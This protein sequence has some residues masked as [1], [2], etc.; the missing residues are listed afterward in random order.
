MK[1]EK[2]RKKTL[3]LSIFFSSF[4]PIVTLIAF[5]MNTSTTQLADFFRRTAEL[6]VLIVAYKVFVLSHLDTVSDEKA[7]SLEKMQK[8]LVGSVLYLS[9]LTL[10]ILLIY[11]IINPSIPSGNVTLGL[12]IATLGILFNGTFWLRY[13]R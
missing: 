12:S 5:F 2:R 8:K 1:E 3:M 13:M 7:E 11:N 10:F 4:G 6:F 9:A